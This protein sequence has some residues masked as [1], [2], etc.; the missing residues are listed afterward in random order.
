MSCLTCEIK[1]SIT[2]EKLLASI[3]PNKYFILTFIVTNY[4]DSSNIIDPMKDLKSMESELNNRI[5]KN[6]RIDDID[7]YEQFFKVKMGSTVKIFI[8]K[9]NVEASDFALKTLKAKA[10]ADVELAE[11]VL[12]KVALDFGIDLDVYE[13]Y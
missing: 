10:K 13:K 7:I 8:F 5:Y 4:V 11:I 2:T 1:E 9:N 12:G 6:Q 3:S